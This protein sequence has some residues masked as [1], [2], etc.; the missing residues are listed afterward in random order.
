MRLC[1]ASSVFAAVLT[2]AACGD[3]VPSAPDTRQLG[4]GGDGPASQV[5]PGLRPV[6]LPPGVPPS[7]AVQL[8]PAGDDTALALWVQ[9]GTVQS[10]VY[11][12][13]AGWTPAT[14]LEDI[15]G[16]ASDAQLATSGQGSALA[17][18]RHTVGRI[19]SLRFSRYEE[20]RGWSTPDVV[21]G[22]LPRPRPAGAPPRL[23]AEG[24]PE[25][26][27]DAEGNA[28]ARWPSG[29]DAEEAQIARYEPGRGWTRAHSEPLA[30]VPGSV[31][32]R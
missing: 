25:L 24:A 3:P 29:F 17:L 22:A 18:W 30:A 8:A 23:P 5:L 9:D 7:T 11:R 13:G 32:P 21:P 16:Q 27:M 28:V 4:A 20:G 31:A 26:V 10:A 19:E 6:P 2:L 12:P 1:L 15:Y 14:P